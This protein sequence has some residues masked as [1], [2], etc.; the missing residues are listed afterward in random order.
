VHEAL[1]DRLDRG[2]LRAER[3]ARVHERD[4]RVG[5]VH[6]ALR[7]APDLEERAGDAPLLPGLRVLEEELQRPA[8]QK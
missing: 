1:L 2:A 5:Q 6:L 4:A 8:Y 3:D 7:A